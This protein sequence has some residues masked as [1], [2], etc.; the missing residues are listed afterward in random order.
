[1]RSVFIQAYGVSIDIPTYY[2]YDSKFVPHYKN[3]IVTTGFHILSKKNK[4]TST[5]Q[6]TYIDGRVEENSLQEIFEST[7]DDMVINLN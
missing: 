6:T 4:L 5:V 3:Y 7:T 2:H 1:M